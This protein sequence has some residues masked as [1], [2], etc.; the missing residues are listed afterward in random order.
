M[1]RKTPRIN[2]EKTLSRTEV[3]WM[4]N[5][6]NRHLQDLEEVLAD[7][8]LGNL[9]RNLAELMRENYAHVREKFVATLDNNW[10]RIYVKQPEGSVFKRPIRNC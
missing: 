5:L 3:Q 8:E 4:I 9:D 2:V 10:T 6:I 7:P 1:P